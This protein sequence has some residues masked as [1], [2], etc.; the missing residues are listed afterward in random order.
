MPPADLVAEGRRVMT[1]CNAC[2][3]CEAYCPVFQAMEDRLTFAKGDIAYLANLCHNCGECLYACQ[4]AP[5]HQFAI[6]VPRTLA[7]IRLATYE[8]YC[9][10]D[11]LRVAFR[12]Q[13]RFVIAAL[14][15][16]AVLLL[17]LM[18]RSSATVPADFYAIIPHDVLVALFSA[19]TLLVVVA[20]AV[21]R[22]RGRAAF[23]VERGL[24]AAVQGT[25][26]SVALRFLH[27]AGDDC[28][29]AEEWRTPWRRRFHHATFYGFALC[30]A[31]TSVA[32]IYHVAFNWPAPYRYSSLPVLLGTAGG[33]GLLIGPAGL[34]ALRNA[35]DAAMTDPSQKGLDTSLI[36]LLFLTSLT[37]LVLLAFREN[38]SMPVLLAV[39]LIT[40]LALFLTMPYGKFV[41]GIHRM[42]ALVKFAGESA[43][44]K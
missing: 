13:F 2:R 29:E 27:G 6:N 11:F 14:A 12:Q 44:R 28:T 9:W 41:H 34:L 22:H 3:Y 4:Y 16:G 43:G 37:G 39:H 8:E 30:F 33:I 24:P 36:A 38:G 7:G 15:V 40:V 42:T 21:S 19:V 1:V 5:P 17:P 35:R 18:R 10:P 23:V 25:R 26:D 32:A 31:S 20:I